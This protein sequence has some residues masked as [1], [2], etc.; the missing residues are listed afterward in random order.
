MNSPSEGT[1]VKPRY[2][3]PGPVRSHADPETAKR[4]EAYFLAKNN[5]S[6]DDTMAFFSKELAAYC[7]ATLGW[8]IAG[9]NAEKALYAKYMPHWGGGLSYPTRILGGPDSAIVAMTDTPELFG[10]EIHA[11]GCVDLLDGLIVRWVDYWDSTGFDGE[12]IRKMT[13][14]AGPYPEDL[15]EIG[16]E[17]RADDTLVSVCGRLHQA[18]SGDMQIEPLFSYDAVYEDMALRTALVGRS[19]IGRYV[20]RLAGRQPFGTGAAIRHKVGGK[21]G[22]GYE[23]IP[24]GGHDVKAGVTALELDNMGLIT[25]LTTVY[26]ARRLGP[27]LKRSLVALSIEGD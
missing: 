26:D 24:S 12:A 1:L 16:T 7:D 8:K 17:I 18:F 6:L 14:D 3:P 20:R 4:L 5:H 9:Y 13:A 27:D 15:G 11:L 25:R 10:G 23:W 2:L 22:G 21:L 19:A